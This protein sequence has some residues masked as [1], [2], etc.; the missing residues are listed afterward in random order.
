MFSLVTKGLFLRLAYVP[1]MMV[2]FQCSPSLPRDCFPDRHP[3][4]QPVESCLF[5]SMFSLVTKGLFPGFNRASTRLREVSM[6]SLVTKGLFLNIIKLRS[7][8]Y[9]V[10][11]FSLVT[12]GLFR[13]HFTEVTIGSD[14]SMFSLVTKGLFPLVRVIGTFAVPFQCSPSLPRDCFP[15]QVSHTK[16]RICVSMFS[17]VTK[18]LFQIGLKFTWIHSM[19]QCSPSLPR[20]CFP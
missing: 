17:L 18:G 9:R 10:S 19:F 8:V 6:F 5:V 15:L 11:M 2:K 3:S 7:E 20:D 16:G 1:L 14:V 13:C 4:Q 12:K